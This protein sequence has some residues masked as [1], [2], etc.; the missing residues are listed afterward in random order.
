MTPNRT[1]DW[2][3]P[4]QTTTHLS[5]PADR[6]FALFRAKATEYE[7]ATSGTDDMLTV[8]SPYGE[9]IVSRERDGARITLTAADRSRLY[10]LQET[11]DHHLDEVGAAAALRW[12]QTDVG[13]YPPNLAFSTVADCA[14]ISPSYYRVRLSDPSLSRFARDGLH[15]RLLFAPAG[16]DGEWPTIAENGRTHWP[17]DINAWHRPVYTV[18]RAN[19]EEGVFDFD[20]FIH[21]GGRTTEWCGTLAGGERVAILGPGGEWHVDTP[22]V[23][24][25]GD[26]TALPAIARHLAALTAEA[27][28]A[29]AIMIGHADDVQDLARPERVDLRWIV[30]DSGE[31]LLD[32]LAGLTIPAKDRFVWFAGEKGEAAAARERLVQAGLSKTEMRTAAYWA[33]GGN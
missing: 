15:F 13:A 4:M 30:R 24:L 21:E 25:F 9:I 28:G 3:E 11:V 22:W 23:G 27:S 8:V 18:R 7:L 2:K 12:S 20:V 6:A 19:P 26:E 5:F 10:V 14:R 29:A 33:R 17:V 32:A 31:T 16:H 1:A